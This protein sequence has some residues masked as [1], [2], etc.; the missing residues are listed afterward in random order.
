[1]EDYEGKAS[2]APDAYNVFD[3][4]ATTIAAERQ[5]SNKNEALQLGLANGLEKDNV[6]NVKILKATSGNVS[7]WL[8]TK[9]ETRVATQASKN[10]AIAIQQV[11]T[12][13]GYV[14][15]LCMQEWKQKIIAKVAHE[16]QVMQSTQTEPMEAQRQSFEMEL[17]RM[18]EELELY[19]AKANKLTDEVYALKNK[20]A[21]LAQNLPTAKKKLVAKNMQTTSD[22]E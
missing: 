18:R 17:E 14:E 3:V 13:E 21:R 1:M 9:Q 20:R 2:D 16:L 19:E 22:I 5:G 11:A 15:K 6:R 12:Q 4:T 7:K 10:G 8:G